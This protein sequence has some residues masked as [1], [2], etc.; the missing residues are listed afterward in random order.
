MSTEQHS[1]VRSQLLAAL[2]RELEQ[3][4]PGAG[5]RAA[6][7]QPRQ[8]AHGDLACTAAMQ[9]AKRYLPDGATTVGVMMNATHVAPTVAG[10]E[11]TATATLL[12][13]GEGQF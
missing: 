5:A 1:S 2:A 11:V 8:A 4:S 3:L 6:F 9:L 13:H 10:R 7:E 12:E